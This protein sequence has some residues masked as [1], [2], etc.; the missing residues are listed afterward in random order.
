MAI[1][2][3]REYSRVDWGDEEGLG[4]SLEQINTGAILR[5]ADAC[6][7]MCQDRESLERRLKWMGED[8]DRTHARLETELRRNAALRGVITRMKRRG[9]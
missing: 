8:R 4:L 6:E 2:G 3:Y 9:E 5:I 1:K 7:K